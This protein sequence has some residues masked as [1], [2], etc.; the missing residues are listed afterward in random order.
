MYGQLKL[1]AGKQWVFPTLLGVLRPPLSQKEP[2]QLVV[3][4]HGMGGT[5]ESNAW[6]AEALRHA[7]P[8]AVIYVPDGLEPMDGNEETRQW[9]GVPKHFKDEWFGI[10]PSKLKAKT[11]RKFRRMYDM[12]DE[13]VP[14]IVEFVRERMNFHGI[15]AQDTYL[16]GVSQGAMMLMQLMAE[17]DVL[18]DR[19]PDGGYIPVGGV[20]IIA[21]C[22]LDVREVEEHP[23][24]S[25]PEFILVHGAKDTTVPYSGHILSEKTLYARGI[26]CVSKIAWD[27]DHTFFEREVLDDILRLAS[28]WGER[29]PR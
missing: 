8:D 17:S 26:P 4:F 6:F 25:K 10:H 23:T 14:K 11:R 1:P 27:K 13:A 29:A 2:K 3:Y 12:Y 21:G 7:M 20:M 5:G 22:L 28:H 16:F 19:A 24:Q 9:F 15:G 18:A